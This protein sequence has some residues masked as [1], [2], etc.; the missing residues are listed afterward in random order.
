MN[1]L[2]KNPQEDF[3]KNLRKVIKRTKEKLRIY[4]PRNYKEIRKVLGKS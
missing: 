2:A 4:L 3:E 1:S